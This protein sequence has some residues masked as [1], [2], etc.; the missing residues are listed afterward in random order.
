MEPATSKD[1]F[2]GLNC[3]DCIERRS[4]FPKEETSSNFSEL[5]YILLLIV[6]GFALRLDFILPTNSIIDADEAIVGLMARHINQGRDIPVF[7]YGQHY[8]GSLESIITAGMFKLFGESNFSLKLTPLVFSLALIP[9]VYLL[10][11][12]YGGRL[13]ARFAAA[14]T[15]IPPIGLV[16]WSGKARGGFIEILV[17]G[18]IA[19]YLAGKFLNNTQRG[20]FNTRLATLSC[21]VLGLGWWVNNQIIFFFVPIGI[22]F[23]SGLRTAGRLDRR[24][25]LNLLCIGFIAFIIGGLPFWIYNL[26]NG[27]ISFLMFTAAHGGAILDQVIGLVSVALP[28]LI[29]SK[30]FWEVRDIFHNA[31]AYFVAPYILVFLLA[32]IA[33]RR[34]KV[35]ANTPERLSPMYLLIFTIATAA[36]FS[37]SSFGYLFKAPRYLLPLYVGLFPLLGVCLELIYRR[38]RVLALV[39]ACLL[40]GNNLVSAYYGGRSIPGEPMVYNGDRVSVDHSELM[41]FLG[42]KNISLVNTNYWIGYRLAFESQEQ[43]RFLMFQVPKTVRIPEY[44]TTEVER[45]R[46]LVP[47][48]LPP[49]QAD[50]VN[51]GLHALGFEFK[52]GRASG[53]EIFYDIVDT[54][55]QLRTIDPRQ[56]TIHAS[57]NDAAAPLAVDGQLGT[58]W[59]SAHPRSPEMYLEVRLAEPTWVSGINLDSRGFE[60][61]ATKRLDIV[62]TDADGV[63]Q[64]IVSDLDYEYGRY[65]DEWR[66]PI[67]FVFQ[68]RKL[69]K[70]V[71]RQKDRD[72]LYDWSYAELSLLTR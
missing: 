2:R 68:P 71:I 35:A 45:L 51:H 49:K 10:A 37:L 4:E 22:M 14:V 59:G 29:G 54:G 44:E 64:L 31:T 23:L 63:D 9:L 60:T 53:Y 16:I 65:V 17:I 48:V 32:V 61:D 28:I 41:D 67:R 62:G 43:I 46:N 70:L 11:F 25:V 27:F 57:H 42:A 3:G 34:E 7:Y 36:I 69:K 19:L 39:L 26:Q 1:N 21:F 18:G 56:F 33:H 50:I 15:A 13:A 58:R 6:I 40:L 20:Y 47:F 72:R 38:S 12:Q 55:T 30:T 5:A 66:E 52:R 8:M 24:G